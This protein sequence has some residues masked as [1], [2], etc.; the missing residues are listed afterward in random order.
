M[1][2]LREVPPTAGFALSA[3]DFLFFA[4]GVTLEERIKKYLGVAYA[5]VSC[6][7]T[8]AY[9]VILEA[10][11]RVSA[12][13][14]VIIPSFVCPLLPLAI[15]RAGLKAVACDTNG[16]DFGYELEALEDI[17]A[18]NVDVLAITAVHLAGIPV[19]FKAVGRVAKK[20]GIFTIED[21]AQAL[22][23]E[24]GGKR[25]GTLADASFFSFCRGKGVTT[26]EGGAIVCNTKELQVPLDAA[27]E[28]LLKPGGLNEFY[29]SALL[30]GYW[31]FYRPRLFWPVFRLPQKFW[32]W[33]KDAVRAADEMFGDDFPVHSVSGFRKSV[34]LA[35]FERLDAAIAGQREK[36]LY[37]IG[38]LKGVKG[39]K[40][41][42]ERPGDKAAYPFVTL[43][44]DDNAR[45]ESALKKIE[46]SG[47]GGSIIYA[48]AI[49]DYGYLK[50]LVA[51][52]DAANG[53]RLAGSTVTLSTNAYLLRR[54]MDKAVNLI[55]SF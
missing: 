12:K 51:C 11:K 49:T 6:S 54:D 25:A 27:A 32:K 20:H 30:L 14:T 16:N 40:A 22:G 10:L 24:I 31:A 29:L 3:G 44:F 37:Y 39:I 34:A 15:K 42:C 52:K 26:Y 8:A 38:A 9:Y 4:K 43:I 53:R 33:R 23:A 48:R 2:I 36:A 28:G 19:D 17:C 5:R 45:R 41:V 18:E 1:G 50:G 47:L 46:A 21:C 55:K 7:G 35:Q 13:R